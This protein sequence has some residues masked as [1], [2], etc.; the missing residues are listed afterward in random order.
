MRKF[1]LIASMLVTLFAVTACKENREP[2]APN[3]NQPQRTM[4]Q[5]PNQP[6]PAER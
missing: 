1:A 6:P 5:N 2:N 3:P 4:P